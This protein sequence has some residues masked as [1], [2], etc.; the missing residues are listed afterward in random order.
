MEDMNKPRSLVL[1]SALAGLLLWSILASPEPVKAATGNGDIAYSDPNDSAGTD[2]YIIAPD[3]SG[4]TDLTNG[5][6]AVNREPSYSPDGS[7]LVFTSNSTAQNEIHS[8]NADGT[9]VVNLT[10]DPGGDGSPD[11]SPAGNKIAFVSDRGGDLDVYAMNVDGTGQVNLTNAPG[12][13]DLFPR[14]SPNG[15]RIAYFSSVDNSIW[16]MNADG[17]GQASLNVIG[18]PMDWS[19]DGTKIAFIGSPYGNHELYVM[20]ADGSGLVNM[21]NTPA[22]EQGPAWSPDGTKIAFMSLRDGDRE[23]WVIP[24]AGGTAVNLSDNPAQDIDPDWQPAQ[25]VEEETAIYVSMSGYGQLPGGEAYGPDDILLWNGQE[26]SIWFDGSAAGLMPSGEWKHDISAMYLPEDPEEGLIVA[27]AQNR[28]PVPGI[29]GKVNGMDLVRWDGAAW[30]MWFDGQDVGL[31]LLTPEKIDAL[32]VLPGEMSPVGSDCRAYLLVSTQGPGRVPAPAGLPPIKFSGEDVLG[33]C[34][35]NAGATTT[36][37]WHKALDGSDVG[38]PR[39][40]LTGLSAS[41]D[42]QTLYLTTRGLFTFDGFTGGHSMVYV[43]DRATGEFSGPILKV[44]DVGLTGKVDALHV[45]DSPP[46]R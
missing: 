20:N 34:M 44:M 8:M 13:S 25:P 33:F 46:R 23:V 6:I 29:P 22:A 35:V 12:S 41:A 39:N 27:F 10:N 3:G 7:R 26:W 40:A 42:G 5:G 21:S 28:R 2:I 43:F 4:Q 11:W 24:A 38:L 9:N 15:Q 14:W 37:L 30:S 31:T 36:G 18:V 19:P 1:S 45:A 32:H 17:S 16:I